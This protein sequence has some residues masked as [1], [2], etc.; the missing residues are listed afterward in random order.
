MASRLGV[1]AQQ[2]ATPRGLPPRTPA[3][4]RLGGFAARTP[5]GQGMLRGHRTPGTALSVGRGSLDSWLA[6][7]GLSGAVRSL[8]LPPLH[9]ASGHGAGKPCPTAVIEMGTE[10][11]AA[12]RC[13]I[14]YGRLRSVRSL[15]KM[16]Q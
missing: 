14:V 4:P 7:T 8:C 1:A 16:G 3:T 12:I 15:C 13:T 6:R 5:A 9:P 10:H 2:A 11:S